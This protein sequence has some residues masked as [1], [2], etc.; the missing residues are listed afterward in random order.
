MALAIVLAGM[1]LF[2]LAPRYG[3]AV[4]F[5]LICGGAVIGIP[6]FVIFANTNAGYRWAGHKYAAQ[7]L[8]AIKAA[9]PAFDEKRFLALAQQ[10]FLAL[11][12]A[13]A[14]RNP[15]EARVYMSPG[16]YASWK[17]QLE[18]MT[19]EGRRRVLIQPRLQST[20][21][22]LANKDANLEAI[23]VRFN[24]R[25]DEA[26]FADNGDRIQGMGRGPGELT[27]YW[28]FVRSSNALSRPD[29]GLFTKTCPNCGASLQLNEIGVCGYC[30]ATVLSGSYDWVL[31]HIEDQ[32]HLI[33][34]QA[35]VE[36]FFQNFADSGVISQTQVSDWSAAYR[37]G[38]Q[39]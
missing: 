19:R 37:G 34:K 7:A 6:A 5:G 33:L 15:D 25:A 20:A 23:T 17:I 22:L 24:G 2:F 14:D 12:Q 27:E 21:V 28:T 30:N 9:D 8:A 1:L 29:G 10:E 39:V 32:G 13:R 38:H 4:Y 35:D 16:L 18:Q 31:S 3:P 26:Y 36:K 11:Q